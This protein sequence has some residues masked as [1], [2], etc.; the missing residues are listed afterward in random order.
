MTAVL[1][2]TV[3]SALHE[4][5]DLDYQSRVWTGR[6]GGGEMSSFVECVSRLYDDSGLELA[7]DARQDVFGLPIDNYLRTLGDLVLKIDSSQ[8]PDVTIVDPRMQRVRDLA[9]AILR[10]L[11][12]RS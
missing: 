3:Q 10:G 12:D 6:A 8:S 1:T 11:R 2:D 9:A 7:L 5:A 4:L